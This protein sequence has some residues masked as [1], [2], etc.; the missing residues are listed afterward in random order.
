M[1]SGFL[2]KD[3]ERCEHKLFHMP[4]YHYK[5]FCDN[6]DKLNLYCVHPELKKPDILVLASGPQICQDVFSRNI[7]EL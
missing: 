5:L 6:K 3:Y 7:W 4:W 2:K 1:L